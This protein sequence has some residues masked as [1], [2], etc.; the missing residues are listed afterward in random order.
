MKKKKKYFKIL[1]CYAVTTLTRTEWIARSRQNAEPCV[2]IAACTV[3]LRYVLLIN[4]QC[5]Q[6]HGWLERTG[7]KRP[8]DGTVAWYIYPL[9]APSLFYECFYGITLP[10]PVPSVLLPPTLPS[11]LYF[12]LPL[13]SMHSMYGSC[14][15]G[16]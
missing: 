3:F 12:S 11:S 5:A 15:A 16:T 4:A 6:I 1:L 8:L 7:Q 14:T 13:F 10:L 2:K 9:S